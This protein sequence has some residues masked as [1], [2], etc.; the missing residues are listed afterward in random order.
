MNMAMNRL[1][2]QSAG[3]VFDA[4]GNI[5]GDKSPFKSMVQPAGPPTK[6]GKTPKAKV[7]YDIFGFPLN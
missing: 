7:K 6:S 1:I 3:A 2:G 5:T 4:F